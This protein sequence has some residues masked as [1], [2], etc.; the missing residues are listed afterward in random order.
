MWGS[1]DNAAMTGDAFKRVEFLFVPLHTKSATPSL[2]SS[3]TGKRRSGHG[4]KTP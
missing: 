1:D 2:R 3:I 4:W